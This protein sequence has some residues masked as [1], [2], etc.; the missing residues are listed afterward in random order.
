[1]KQRSA[2]ETDRLKQQ[3]AEYAA[4]LVEP[5]MVIGLGVGSTVAHALRRIADRYRSGELRDIV[6]VPCSIRTAETARSLGIPLASLEEQ[7]AIDLT[8]DGADEVDRDLNLIK[9]AGGALLR[10]KIVAQVSRREVIAIDDSKLSTV[11]G[12]SSPLPVEVFPFGWST[13]ARF[14]ETLGAHVSLRCDE[15]GEPV[16]TDQGL[17]VLD[18]NF[19]PIT[20]LHDLAHQIKGRAGIVEHGLFLGLATDVIVASDNGVEHR[21]RKQP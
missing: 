4:E 16:R 19:G 9:G 13:Q 18:C 20:N 10:E 2:A 5:G 15:Q 14:L 7:P 8:I 12:E 11:L 1:M 6:G 3:A 21:T 17:L